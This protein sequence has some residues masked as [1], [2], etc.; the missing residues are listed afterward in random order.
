[1][2]REDNVELFVRRFQLGH[3]EAFVDLHLGSRISIRFATIATHHEFSG[4]NTD[5]I[6]FHTRSDFNHLTGFGF[7]SQH[8]LDPVGPERPAFSLHGLFLYRSSLFWHYRSDRA[9]LLQI[10]RIVGDFLLPVHTGS[11]CILIGQFLTTLDLVESFIRKHFQHVSIEITFIRSIVIDPVVKG[12]PFLICQLHIVVTFL[13]QTNE[14]AR[15]GMIFVRLQDDH[16]TF[17]TLAVYVRM[18]V[19]IRRAIAQLVFLPATQ[20]ER[21]SFTIMTGDTSAIQDRLHFQVERKGAS[22][23]FGQSQGRRS[24]L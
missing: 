4:R 21:F 19:Q 3:P 24:F 16:I 13:Q 23:S 18:Q 11:V 17:T 5:E 2:I 22:T 12:L 7:L 9:L 6:D 1:M 8:F 10:I 20:V 14:F 15:V